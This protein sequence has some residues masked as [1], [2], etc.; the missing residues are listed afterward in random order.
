[1]CCTRGCSL[2]PPPSPSPL[3]SV[4]KTSGKEDEK[5]KALALCVKFRRRHCVSAPSPSPTAASGIE[6]QRAVFSKTPTAPKRAKRERKREREEERERERETERVVSRAVLSTSFALPL[7]HR[8]PLPQRCRLLLET[9]QGAIT[10]GHTAAG[11]HQSQRDKALK[12]HG[13]EN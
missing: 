6:R 5:K 2:A 12:G 7:F 4:R 13:G 1:M 10:K 3:S 9:Q 11:P 8:L